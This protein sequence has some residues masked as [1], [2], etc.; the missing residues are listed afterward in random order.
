M[1]NP[2]QLRLYII[3]TT[4]LHLDPVI[5]YSMAA[6][7]LLMGTCAQE[8]AM[9]KYRFQINGPAVGIFQMEPATHQDHYANYLK[10]LDDMINKLFDINPRAGIHGFQWVPDDHWYAAAMCR[11]HYYRV[12]DPLPEDNPEALAQ[13]WKKFYNTEQGKGTVEEFVKNYERYVEDPVRI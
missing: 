6:E 2:E 8:S 4:L 1:L 7:N 3:R 11:V 13:Y 10:Y 12:S 9:G 5:P